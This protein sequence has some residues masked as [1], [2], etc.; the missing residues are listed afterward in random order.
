MLNN[1][2]WVRQVMGAGITQKDFL[3]LDP[4][5]GE[6]KYEIEISITPNSASESS[7][8]PTG[9][10]VSINYALSPDIVLFTKTYPSETTAKAVY[11]DLCQASATVEGLLKQEK[12]EEAAQKTKELIS[13]FGVNSDQPPNQL[14]ERTQ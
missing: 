1:R 12:L 4:K 5:G 14:P 13:K 8:E 7:A 3:I 10:T 9:W 11:D 2:A 6:S